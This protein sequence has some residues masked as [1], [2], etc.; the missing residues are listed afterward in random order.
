MTR[1]TS[2]LL[3][4]LAST[5]LTGCFDFEP[6]RIEVADFESAVHRVDARTGSGDIDVRVDEDATQTIVEAHVYGERTRPRI[7]KEDGVLTL[8]HDCPRRARQCGVDWV[9]IL[10]PHDDARIFD[11]DSGSGD[12]D[13]F[14]TWGI[15]VASTGSGDI[16]LHGVWAEDID[17]DTGSGDIGIDLE[18]SFLSLHADTGSGDVGI[19]IPSGSYDLS[20]TT[21]SGDVSTRDID[22][23]AS[24]EAIVDVQTGSGDVSVHGR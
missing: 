4:L 11:L 2:S 17:L 3:A 13:L 15:T 14:G 6:D 21:G 8:R 5:T 9:V 1:L 19:R 23:D 12:I 16:G 7:L 18:G 24:A 10:P 22:D 20:I